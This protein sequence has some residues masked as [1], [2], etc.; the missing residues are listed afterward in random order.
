MSQSIISQQLQSEDPKQRFQAIKKAARSKD[1]SVLDLLDNIASNDPDNQVRSVAARAYAYILGDESAIEAPPPSEKKQAAPASNG[2]VDVS[3]ANSHLNSALSLQ[4]E[5]QRNKALKAIGKALQ[6]NPDFRTDPYFISILE[7]TTRLEGEEAFDM[8]F[9]KEKIKHVQVSEKQM[10][11]EKVSGDHWSEVEKSNWASASMDLIIFTLIT[12]I[13]TVLMVLIAQQ[14]AQNVF[15]GYT[16]ALDAYDEAI[17]AGDNS[18]TLPI[19]NFALETVAREYR[20]LPMTLGLV[21]GVVMGI[22]SLLQLLLH[23]GLTHLLARY[24]FRGKGTLPHLIYNVV[25]LYNT[26]L[27]VILFLSYMGIVMAFSGDM[28]VVSMLLFGASSLVSLLVIFGIFM[29]TGKTYAFGP[30]KGF[31][32]IMITLV[33]SYILPGIVWM[34]ASPLFMSMIPES[35]LAMPSF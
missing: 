5:G 21:G 28:E 23:L 3:M 6:A 26:R 22:V 17:D 35:L 2:R 8:L 32:A 29:R 18:A 4:I 9:D 13:G 16:A 34:L 7:A 24:I 30:V 25:S 19:R 14:S 1:S 20:D 33:P 11:K 10:A 15:T 27:P 12:I 31:L